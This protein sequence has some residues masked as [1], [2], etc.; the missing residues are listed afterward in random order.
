MANPAKGEIRFDAL[1]KSW[2]M[3][4]GFN[5]ICALEAQF[6]Q[7]FAVIW[8]RVFP[9]VHG[10]DLN[11]PE[12]AAAAI[13]EASRTLRMTD[14][15][16]LF[17]AALQEHQPEATDQEAGAIIGELGVQEAMIL[18]REAITVGMKQGGDASPENP[19]KGRKRPG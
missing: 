11:D 13:A 10:V 5:A 7:P 9:N 6:D 17:L 3:M 8:E 12:A 16:S 14:V 2:L 18:L 19:R 15:R 1:G 4:F